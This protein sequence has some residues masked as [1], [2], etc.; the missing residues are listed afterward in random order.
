MATKHAITS[1][2]TPHELRSRVPRV[3]LYVYVCIRK[4]RAYCGRFFDQ[5]LNVLQF[6][7]E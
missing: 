5:S 1:V 7:D 2:S 4:R 6:R 3:G